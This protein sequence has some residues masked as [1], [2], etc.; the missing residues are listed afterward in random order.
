MMKMANFMLCSSYHIFKIER[1]KTLQGKDHSTYK[2]TITMLQPWGLRRKALEEG[3]VL[4]P[5][6]FNIG[7][8][9]KLTQKQP[10]VR[11][12]HRQDIFLDHTHRRR[13]VH[14]LGRS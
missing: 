6:L 12:L 1:E 10:H 14:P 9:A 4:R 11:A 3:G 8:Q 13:S 2:F 5:V 7:N